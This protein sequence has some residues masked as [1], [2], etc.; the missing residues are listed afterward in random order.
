[1][2]NFVYLV[3]SRRGGGA[4]IISPQGTVLDEAK[5][6]ND[7]ATADIDPFGGR[8]AGD[9][10]DFQPDMR[11]RLFRERNPAAYGILTDP[12]P[13]VFTKVPATTT[14][15]DAVRIAEKLLTAGEER[16]QRAEAVLRLGKNR[17][18]YS[19]FEA[20]R[21]EFPRTWI[22]RAAK[23]QLAEIRTAEKR[24]DWRCWEDYIA[25]ILVSGS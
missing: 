9:V 15:E 10:F 18:A 12:E 11:A 3:I 16:Y 24:D 22:E 20:L 6:A 21:V 14:V 25:V 7:I 8:A 2:D 1:M 23:Q 13:P 4:M 5:G 17:E 19:A